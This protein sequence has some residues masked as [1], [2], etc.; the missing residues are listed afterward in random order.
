MLQSL[1]VVVL[2][3]ESD[4]FKSLCIFIIDATAAAVHAALYVQYRCLFQR[5][6]A[7]SVSVSSHSFMCTSTSSSDSDLCATSVGLQNNSTIW[8]QTFLD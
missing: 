1:T 4:S 5:Q 6:T 8:H 2:L 3:C 7:Q